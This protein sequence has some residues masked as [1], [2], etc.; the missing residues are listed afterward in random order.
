MIKTLGNK[1][2]LLLLF[3]LLIAGFIRLYK[4][5]QNPPALYWDEVSLGYNAYAVMTTG[6]DEH[7]ELFPLARFIAFGDYK[8][9]GYIYALIPGFLLLGANDLT[10]RLPSAVSGILMVFLTYVLV[11]QLTK[12]KLP[13]LMAALVLAISPWSLQL[14]RAAFEAHL[15]AL[16]HLAAILC[17]INIHKRKWF[18]L[19]SVVL[20]TLSFY[21]FNAN[22]IL[23]PLFVILLSVIYAKQLLQMKRWVLVS[24]II[25]LLMLIPSITYLQSRESRLRFQEVS[26]FTSLNIIKKSNERIARAGNTLWA[27]II[28][29][30]RVY[31]TREFL[32]HYVD[33]FRGDYLFVSGDRNPRLSIQDVGELYIYEAPFLVLGLLYFLYR[34]DKVSALL[35]GWLLLAPIPAATARETPH[36]LRTASM[37]PVPQIFVA[38]G[39]TIFINWLSKKRRKVKLTGIG[40]LLGIAAFSFIY[41]MHNY[42]IHYPATYGGEWQYGYKQMV[43]EVGKLEKNFEAVQVTLNLG[44][45]YIYFLWYNRIDPL[46]YVES[47]QAERDWYGLW[48][49]YGFGKYEFGDELPTA[50]Q[51]TLKVTSAGKLGEGAQKLSEIK[52]LDTSTVF[53]IGQP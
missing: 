43:E 2:S 13:A 46:T 18:L 45:P 7:G 52:G 26:I 29:N 51:Q 36:M 20:F 6:H 34:R 35:F 10:V 19:I 37:L 5:D 21:T 17:F 33:H 48:N 9:P 3:I 11:E 1:F 12:R 49:V 14:S 32:I 31:F 30:R 28:H 22:R 53:E 39:I 38:M 23:A 27:K 47:R 16:L 24:I 25:G 8:P 15:A 50:R 40:L 4:L 42:W 41:Y 44:R